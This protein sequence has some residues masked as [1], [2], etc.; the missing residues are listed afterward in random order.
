MKYGL[1]ISYPN[2]LYPP[3]T[4]CT[5][6]PPYTDSCILPPVCKDTDISSAGTVILVALLVESYASDS[7]CSVWLS[8]KPAQR[9]VKFVCKFL[10][11]LPKELVID[12]PL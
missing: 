6:T 5:T 9:Y 3:S 7:T 4:A 10:T 11:T 12:L 2:N 8:I 1:T